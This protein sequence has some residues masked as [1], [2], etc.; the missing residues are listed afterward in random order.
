MTKHSGK[1][2]TFSEWTEGFWSYAGHYMVLRQELWLFSYSGCSVKNQTTQNVSARM[3][4]KEDWGQWKDEI[5]SQW[6][7]IHWSQWRRSCFGPSFWAVHIDRQNDS[8]RSFWV[9]WLGLAV[10]KANLISTYVLQDVCCDTLGQQSLNS[11]NPHLSC[12]GVKNQRPQTQIWHFINLLVYN[13]LASRD[14]VAFQA[15]TQYVNLNP[16]SCSIYVH[17]VF[18][19]AEPPIRRFLLCI[20]VQSLHCT[21]FPLLAVLFSQRVYKYIQIYCNTETFIYRTVFV[22]GVGKFFHCKRKCQCSLSS[23]MN[24]NARSSLCITFWA[25]LLMQIHQK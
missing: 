8:H 11:L 1:I 12:A 5:C 7:E 9:F 16:A 23:W 2:W 25:C 24:L 10:K 20:T 15:P 21:F 18:I 17:L 14:F 3:L 13:S 4:K 22:S 6:N 19:S